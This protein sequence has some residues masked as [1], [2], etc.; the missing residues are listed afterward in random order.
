MHSFDQGARPVTRSQTSASSSGVTPGASASATIKDNNLGALSETLA[1][2]IGD[3]RLTIQQDDT[4]SDIIKALLLSTIPEQPFLHKP[5]IEQYYIYYNFY[6]AMQDSLAQFDAS[7]SFLDLSLIALPMATA[8][9][10]IHILNVPIAFYNNPA[11]LDTPAKRAQCVSNIHEHISAMVQAIGILR[12]NLKSLRDEKK[13]IA[14]IATLQNLFDLDTTTLLSGFETHWREEKKRFVNDF[15]QQS[16]VAD[17]STSSSSTSIYRRASNSNN[18][19]NSTSS[20]SAT[21]AVSEA[22]ADRT[23]VAL[24][25]DTTIASKQNQNGDTLL[26]IAAKENKALV[27]TTCLMLGC[28]PNILNNDRRPAIAYALD[29]PDVLK[30]LVCFRPALKD[31]YTIDMQALNHYQS[32]RLQAWREKVGNSTNINTIIA[33]WSFASNAQNHYLW[34][35]PVAAQAANDLEQGLDI[36]KMYQ[37]L[38]ALIDAKKRTDVVLNIDNTPVFQERA[39]IAF[40]KIQDDFLVLLAEKGASENVKQIYTSYRDLFDDMNQLAENCEPIQKFIRELILTNKPAAAQYADIIKDIMNKSEFLQAHI[41][42]TNGLITLCE[43]LSKVLTTNKMTPAAP[44]IRE[45]YAPQSPA[46]GSPLKRSAS[47]T[48]SSATWAQSMS[49]N[50]MVSKIKSLLDNQNHVT[51]SEEHCQNL[52]NF[53]SSLETVAAKTMLILNAYLNYLAGLHLNSAMRRQF[54]LHHFMAG[55]A[56]KISV[57]LA[58]EQENEAYGA[59]IVKLFVGTVNV[60]PASAYQDIEKFVDKMAAVVTSSDLNRFEAAWMDMETFLAEEKS[61]FSKRLADAQEAEQGDGDIFNKKQTLSR[62]E[63]CTVDWKTNKVHFYRCRQ[64]TPEPEV[65]WLRIISSASVTGHPILKQ[66]PLQQ[67]LAKSVETDETAAAR[68]HKIAAV[69]RLSSPRN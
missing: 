54:N 18:N 16:S 64:F 14:K 12:E 21:P 53:I 57:K 50:T 26:H 17:T 7:E 60:F 34:F 3:I 19:N 22:W 40:R 30:Q 5:L 27:A 11:R 37:M 35:I 45:R 58:E 42:K 47:A 29:K 61:I 10:H 65:R 63:Q 8:A 32:P 31:E 62:F 55:E 28:D 52:K 43:E 39:E 15:S 20:T 67:V 2:F 68:A 13:E 38:L 4:Y 6:T 25:G 23:T 24:G 49:P 51:L 48:N 56:D 1:H 9:Q 44:K 69:M 66:M 41:N 36:L 33:S 59:I 46:D